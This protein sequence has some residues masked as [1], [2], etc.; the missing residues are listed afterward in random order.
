MNTL[1]SAWG[2]SDTKSTETFP[3][4]AFCTSQPSVMIGRVIGDGGL[5]ERASGKNLA[6]N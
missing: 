6:P 3:V 1:Q 4:S 2:Y 5:E